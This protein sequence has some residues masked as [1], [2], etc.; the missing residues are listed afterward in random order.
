MKRT[1]LFVIACMIGLAITGCKKQMQAE[2]AMLAAKTE[3]ISRICLTGTNKITALQAAENVLARLNFSIHKLDIE[4]GYLLSKPLRAA[5]GFEFWRRDNIGK[6]NTAEANLHTIR[7]TVEINIT[8]EA[9]QL[10]IT[11]NVAV[12]RL[13][14][15]DYGQSQRTAKYDRYSEGKVDFGVQELELQ[16]EYKTW[17]DLGN[18]D[19]L[20]TVIL[21]QIDSRL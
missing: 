21:K 8:E 12:Q 6:F 17:I 7:R 9:Q 3:S 2:T 14:L 10:C 18:D 15:S 13:S 16:A 19:K 11:C 4:S 20:A 5:Q 1:L